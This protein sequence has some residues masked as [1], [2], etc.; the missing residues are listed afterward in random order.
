MK[1]LIKKIHNVDFEL[2]YRCNSCCK[3]C[4]N[5]THKRTRE[6]DTKKIIG[7]TKEIKDIGFKEIHY[8]GGEPLLRKDIY[9]ILGYSSDIGLHTVLETNATYLTSP[10]KINLKG[11]TVRASIDGSEKVHNYIRCTNNLVN[12]YRLSLENL[13]K[14]KAIGI[15]VQITGSINSLNHDSIYQMASE[16][17]EYHLD[18]I[19]LRLTMPTGFAIKNWGELEMSKNELLEVIR[20]VECIKEKFSSI[21]LNDASLKRGAPKFEPKFFIDPK[22]FVKPYPF[23]EYFAGDLNKESVSS[24]LEKIPSFKLPVPEEIRMIDYL[25]NLGMVK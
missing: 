10:E 19:R 16:I 9:D 23:I 25:K 24:I 14:T 20:Q 2:T 5:P 4:Y 12:S 22:G 11:L 3:H 15:P 7:I 18:D 21:H 6:L 13:A 17:N 8:N 1:G